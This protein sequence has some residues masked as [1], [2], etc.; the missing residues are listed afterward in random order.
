MQSH[1]EGIAI[2]A[3]HNDDC[4]IAAARAAENNPAY[5]NTIFIG[6]D[7]N[8][9]AAQS[10]LDGGETMTVAQAC[11]NR[12]HTAR[13]TLLARLW[14]QQIAPHRHHRLQVDLACIIVQTQESEP[15]HQHHRGDAA[16]SRILSL[17]QIPNPNILVRHDEKDNLPDIADC[18][19]LQEI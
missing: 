15:N 2:I 5:A 11:G 18:F 19:C 6:F 1:P 4:A 12:L 17:A 16:A 13:W 9:T 8:L 7:G 14:N 10:I 3:C